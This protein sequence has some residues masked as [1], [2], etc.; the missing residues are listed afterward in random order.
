V[1]GLGET[2]ERK[3]ASQNVTQL[4]LTVKNH[5]ELK[6]LPKY[7]TI[8][9]DC[10]KLHMTQIASSTITADCDKLHRTRC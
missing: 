10:E 6:W 5:T 8:S 1:G 3:P 7:G 2:L 4:L 9:A